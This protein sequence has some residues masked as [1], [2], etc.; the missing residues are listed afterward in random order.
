MLPCPDDYIVCDWSKIGIDRKSFMQ[1]WKARFRRA[2]G[3]PRVEIRPDGEVTF[4][5]FEFTLENTFP[6]VAAKAQ[7]DLRVCSSLVIIGGGFSGPKLRIPDNSEDR[8]FFNVLLSSSL[9]L[10][11]SRS[12]H[13]T[14][15]FVFPSLSSH[16]L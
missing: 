15:S 8:I 7:K 10:R 14:T 2:Y 12:T 16:R 1:C 4:L 9:S 13:F 5:N 6:D 3:D 11:C